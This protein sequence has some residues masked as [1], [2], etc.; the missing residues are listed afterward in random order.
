MTSQPI[1]IVGICGDTLHGNPHS[2]PPPQFFIPYVQ[3]VSIRRLTYEIRSRMRPEAMVPA[4]RRAM[5]AADPGLPRVH[6]RTQ[7]QQ[8]D[9]DLAGERL[10]VTLTSRFGALALVL[11][12]VGIFGVMAYSVP[13]RTNEMGI[14]MAVGTIPRQ[15]LAMVL[16]EG[17][18][19][20]AA[21][22]RREWPRHSF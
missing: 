21:V 9:E 19:L 3:Q 4:L 7:R 6:V 16:R 14:R 17:S 5:H 8:V 10:F 18:W 15:V 2:P 11:A 1:E 20:S 22:W 13:Q 12:A